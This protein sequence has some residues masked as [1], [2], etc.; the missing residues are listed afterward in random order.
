MPKEE[1]H[2]KPHGKQR[3]GGAERA[4][5]VTSQRPANARRIYEEGRRPEHHGTTLQRSICVSSLM[6]G[7][8]SVASA[9]DGAAPNN[10][11]KLL[12]RNASLIIANRLTITANEK[13]DQQLRHFLS[14]L[15]SPSSHL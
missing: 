2:E 6:D 1:G 5:S 15:S 14:F 13:S 4:H 10:P 8:P 7:Q 9:I 11:A 3:E 12:G